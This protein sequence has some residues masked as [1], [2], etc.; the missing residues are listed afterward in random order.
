[1]SQHLKAKGRCLTVHLGARAVNTSA[2]TA[3]YILRHRDA[4]GSRRSTLPPVATPFYAPRLRPERLIAGGRVVLA[5]S[6]L[7]AVWLDVDEPVRF[8]P[9]AYGVLV[10]YVVYAGVVA[11]CLWR[12]ETVPLRWSVVTHATD[13]VCFSLFI[14]FTEGPASPFTVYFV[15]A[16]LSATLRWQARGT[17]WTAL[18]VI[19]A[20]I[21]FGLYFGI[22]LN[23]EFD[24]RALIIRGVYLLVLAVLLRYVGTQDQRTVREMWGLAAWPHTVRAD[25]VSLTKDL[26]AYAATLQDA[27]KVVLAWTELDA[28]WSHVAV[29]SGGASTEERHP[30]DR[31]LVHE[32][33][34]DRAFIRSLAPS[35]RTLV[36][37]P[38]GP[39]LARWDGE[40]ID[41]AIAPHFASGATLSVPIRGESVEGRLFVLARREA[42]FDDLVLT[43]IVA[44][45]VG[46]RLDA[47]Y[48][49]EQLR[50][51]AATEERIRLARD[52]HDGV[53]QSFTGIALRLPAIRGLMKTDVTA[54]ASA[55]DD[56][57]RVL[58]SEQR[59]LRFFIQELKPAAFP[60][61]DLPLDVRLGE[62][63]Q[64]MERE[65]D[66]HVDL[67]V[68]T[69]SEGI[70]AAMSRDVY[71][72]VREALVN[73]ARHGAASRA[74]VAI[75]AAGRDAFTV[76]VGDNGRGFPFSGR[77]SAEELARLDLGP[78]T[79]RERVRAINGSLMLESGPRGAELHVVLP[80]G[81]AA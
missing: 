37:D 43:E 11:A 24:L 35:P 21:G 75:G 1:M 51:A 56:V 27:P 70:S 49:T 55:L 46:A 30:A 50:Q 61:K 34:R 28:P 40:P 77:Y 7:F 18:V 42:T 9:V 81:A 12:M 4:P 41:D 52:L 23:R 26:L 60:A 53:L 76:S 6:S 63:A 79:L 54:A 62:L 3:G 17:F 13:L 47:F 19:T 78:K 58:A 32:A 22:V 57:Q 48:L 69:A 72:I 68:E 5:V 45:V 71:H 31:P 44:G 33:V 8:A 20:F 73:A 64:L 14:F 74:R 38:N 59:E 16:L 36:Q 67:R 10:G 80:G 2:G 25:A 29:W 65:W 15:F 66:L 39:H